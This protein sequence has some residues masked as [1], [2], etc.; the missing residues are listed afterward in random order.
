MKIVKTGAPEEIEEFSKIERQKLVELLCT[1]QD[2]LNFMFDKMFVNNQ[3]SAPPQGEGEED[4][5]LS[6]QENFGAP[7]PNFMQ[8]HDN[9][10][11]Q[12]QGGSMSGM[13]IP[14]PPQGPS[15]S[16]FLASHPNYAQLNK[17]S[18]LQEY[19]QEN[20]QRQLQHLANINS[21]GTNLTG[22]T[23]PDHHMTT[24]TIPPEQTPGGH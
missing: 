13:A 22:M 24:Q 17:F 9:N 14:T 15:G 4:Q 20:Q 19:D 12:N 3:K 1:N 21:G 8:S 10:L 16:H 7:S 2:L 5:L 18:S 11:H 23:S 6:S